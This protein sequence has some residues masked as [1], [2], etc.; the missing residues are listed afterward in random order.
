[1]SKSRDWVDLSDDPNYK[2]LVIF[3]DVDKGMRGAKT[4]PPTRLVE[5]S[6]ETATFL[7]QKC[8]KQLNSPD[9]LAVRYHFKFAYHDT[10]VRV[11]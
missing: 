11:P 10:I 5:V 3:D 9:C 2:E 1:M 7:K 8:S 4:A 6:E